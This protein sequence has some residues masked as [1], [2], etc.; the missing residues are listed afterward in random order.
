MGER[1]KILMLTTQLG[2]GGAETSFIRLANFLA[3]SMDVTVALFTSNYG[4]GGYSQGHEPLNAKIVLLD[5]LK[6]C[7]KLK[8][9]WQRIKTLRALKQQ[10]DATIS[11][12]SGP[13]L[14]NVLAGNNHRTVVSLRGSRAYDPV[15]TTF[16]RR[17]FQYLIDPFVFSYAAR[18]VPVSAGLQNEIR[19]AAG[20]K[21]LKKVRVISPFVDLEAVA[22]R[23][24]QP[25]AEPYAGLQGQQV[26]VGVGRMSVEKGFHHLIHVFAKVA[27]QRP[28]AKLL[29]VG[30][31]PMVPALRDLCAQLHLRVDDM[32]AGASAVIF[33]GYQ[34]NPL[35]FMALARGYAM[36]SAT[37]GFPS[38][39][40]E[41][42]A[43]GT[44]IVAADTPWGVRSILWNTAEVLR[45][46]YPTTD[47]T[48]ADYGML[49]PRIDAPEY[50]AL[51]V[52]A[53][54]DC[55][56]ADVNP[57]YAHRVHDFSI[58]KVG[59]QWK[60]VIEELAA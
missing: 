34:K 20:E 31:G 46:P 8:R 37:E 6:T 45:E 42:M 29:L 14:V 57:S 44:P 17:L 26:I 38:V 27:A 22:Q 58:E 32:T 33:A 24:K 60:Q 28:G 51:W 3:Q 23:L 13:N 1:K 56:E 48:A 52:R 12:L 39:L 15:A 18:I 16:Q 40:L 41:A 49:M 19:A 5:T 47:A 50:E 36:T 10:H 9:W 53:L 54:S 55:L 59:A 43:A 30:D 7:G 11:F 21:A 4:N 2:Y 35:P 25:V